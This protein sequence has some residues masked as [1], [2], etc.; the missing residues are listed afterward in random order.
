MKLIA[1]ILVAAV[2]AAHGQQANEVQ[3]R[4]VVTSHA[5]ATY[6]LIVTTRGVEFRDA[7]LTKA[8]AGMLKVVHRDGVASVPLA[9]MPGD[10][11]ARF[12]YDPQAAAFDEVLRKQEFEQAE[13]AAAE[14]KAKRAAE[15]AQQ[16]AAQA[17]SQAAAAELRAKI[18]AAGR[19]ARITSYL[20]REGTTARVMVQFARQGSTGRR[21]MSGAPVMGLV[22]EDA[23][24]EFQILVNEPERA[25]KE[26][27]LYPMKPLSSAFQ[28]CYTRNLDTAVAHEQQRGKPAPKSTK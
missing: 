10:I 6:A 1:F 11:K 9:E 14:R 19:K 15:R 5:D 24:E 4:V 27:M 2:A 23:K 17:E 28:M 3:P 13:K 26:C 25:P 18:E 7:K 12:D 20:H 16:V 22:F 8:S 21:T